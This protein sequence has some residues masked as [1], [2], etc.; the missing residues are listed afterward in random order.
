M[1]PKTVLRRVAFVVVMVVLAWAASRLD[2]SELGQRVAAASPSYLG[3]MLAAWLGAL[4]G[5]ACC[6]LGGPMSASSGH[7]VAVSCEVR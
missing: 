6:A 5:P 4:L 3:G 7:A 1:T 2:W